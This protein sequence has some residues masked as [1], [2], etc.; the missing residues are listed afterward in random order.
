MTWK[1][2]VSDRERRK[3]AEWPSSDEQAR[4]DRA[5]LAGTLPGYCGTVFALVT[6]PRGNF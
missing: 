6:R 3:W 5:N 2:H 4:G 1:R